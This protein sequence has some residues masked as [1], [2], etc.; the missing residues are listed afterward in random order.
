[1][2]WILYLKLNII[3]ESIKK[4]NS[5]SSFDDPRGHES[6]MLWL[7]FKLSSESRNILPRENG[8]KKKKKKRIVKKNL[9]TWMNEEAKVE[10]TCT[11][12]TWWTREMMVSAWPNCGE[13]TSDH[14][15]ASEARRRHHS[16]WRASPWMHLQTRPYD[17]REESYQWNDL[18]QR[19][20]ACPS[21]HQVWELLC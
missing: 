13:Q 9:S 4:K 16:V 17:R 21:A 1:M 5:T 12:R 20:S 7:L 3:L 18:F 8:S 14:C 2:A 10:K 15:W 19:H 11:L 6:G